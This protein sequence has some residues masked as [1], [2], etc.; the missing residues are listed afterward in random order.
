MEFQN[1][2]ADD[3]GMACIV[4]TL[5]TS[6]PCCLFRNT[7][8]NL[9]FSFISPL[10]SKNYGGWHFTLLTPMP[11]RTVFE[12]CV[13]SPWYFQYLDHRKKMICGYGNNPLYP[14]LHSSSL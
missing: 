5:E 7:V 9:S 4:P 12:L 3:D 14:L 1:L 8:N 6:N 2:I 11:S 13:C 10:G